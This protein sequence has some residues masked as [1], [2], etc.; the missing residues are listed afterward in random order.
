MTAANMIFI[1]G[2]G[3]SGTSVTRE[4]MG[5]HQDVMSFPFEYRFMIDPDG[6]IDFV[7]AHQDLW[8]PYLFDRKL[9]RL[10]KL[11]TRMGRKRGLERFVSSVIKRLRMLGIRVNPSQYLNWELHQHFDG[12]MQQVEQ[13]I[14]DLRSFSFDGYWVGAPSYKHNYQINYVAPDQQKII[15][16]TQNFLDKLFSK[17]LA[18]NKKKVLVED[19]TWNLLYCR[20]LHNLFADAKFIHVHRDPR[21]VVCSYLSQNWM[22]SD[23]MQAA[24]ICRDLYRQIELKTAYLSTGLYMQISL[25]EL[26]ND[27]PSALK[28]LCEFC[29]LQF[30]PQMLAIPMQKRAIGMWKTQLNPAQQQQLSDFFKQELT[31]LG[32]SDDN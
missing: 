32:Y 4:L 2:V 25:Q 21:D 28:R 31:Q 17:L 26:V 20:Q 11:L 29:Q 27:L 19:N 13:Y 5:L 7:F 30:E 10:E 9:T 16:V 1:G 18:D 3:R 14:A 24:Q 6:I 8:S 23:L 12:F 15:K 22:P